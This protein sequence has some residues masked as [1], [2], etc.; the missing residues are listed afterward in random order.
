MR[1]WHAPSRSP[2]ANQQRDMT[3]SI[4][5]HEVAAECSTAT[6]IKQRLF[7]VVEDVYG[8]GTSSRAV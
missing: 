1:I 4:G 8:V 6:I 3:R 5:G 7:V 2:V